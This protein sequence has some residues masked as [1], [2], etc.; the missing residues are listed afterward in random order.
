MA[1]SEFERK[2]IEVEVGRFVETHRPPENIRHQLDI[3]FRIENQSVLFFE[4]RPRWDKP[5]EKMESP[6]AKA[7]YGKTERVW[8]VYWM[9]SDLKWHRYDPDPQVSH[10]SDFLKLVDE[11]KNGCFWG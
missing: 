8:K 11:D 9:R 1:L 4:I 3:G 6:V 2:K 7:T 10:L 5:D